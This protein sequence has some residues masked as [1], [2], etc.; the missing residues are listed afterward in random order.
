M[1]DENI[2]AVACFAVCQHLY[3]SSDHALV[4]EVHQPKYKAALQ[5]RD[6]SFVLECYF[7]KGKF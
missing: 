2:V 4:Q 3:F 6:Q 7:Y 5:L 1:T